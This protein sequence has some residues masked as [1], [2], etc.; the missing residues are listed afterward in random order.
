MRRY[1]LKSTR[2][3]LS[4]LLTGLLACFFGA[5]SFS[6]AASQE[7]ETGPAP[8]FGFTPRPEKSAPNKELRFLRDSTA[9]AAISADELLEDRERKR[10]IGR[11]FADLRFLGKRIQADHIEVQTETRDAVA[12]GNIIFQTD[13][14]RIVGSRIE[15]NLD[16]EK[17]VIYD[18]RGY[19]GATYYITGTVIRRISVDR[20]EIIDGTFTTCEGDNPDWVFRS[21]KATF[22][23]EGYAHLQTPLI[24]LR[25]V[26]AAALPYA[27]FPIKSKRATGF[28]IPTYGFGGRN[29]FE[30]TP[31]FFWAIN[32]WSDTTLGVD[33]YEK[34]GSRYL[35]ELRYILSKDTAGKFNAS[36][37]K[38]ELEKTTLW[39]I[40]GSHSSLLPGNWGFSGVVDFASR[41]NEDRSLE[42]NLVDRVRQDTDTR[43]GF[44]H[45]LGA[46]PG[47]LRVAM[48]RREGLRENDGDL[49][50][51]F[52]EIT[53]DINKAQIGTSE[54]RY[55]I[56]S[57]AVSFYR[58]QNK[59]TTVLQRFDAAPSLS[60]PVQTVPWLGVTANFGL[61]Y[62]Y[63]T[64]QKRTPDVAG[65]PGRDDQKQSPLSREIWFSSFG[66][67][68]PRFSRVY[69]GEFGPFRD[70]KH[71]VSLQTTYSYAPAM[72]SRDRKLII[73]IDSVDRFSDRNTVSYG[74][75]NR[76]L[77]KLKTGDGFETRQ[78]FTASLTQSA[79]IAEARRE[80]NLSG[81]PRRPF[82]DVVLNIQS[83]PI[84][85][86][87]FTH[88]AIYDVYEHEIDEQTT[89]LFLEGG[90][91]WYLGLDR[92]WR[93]R[94]SRGLDPQTGRSDLNFS[95]GYALSRQWFLEY[96]TRINNVSNITL[97]Q[98]IILRYAG[99]CWGFNL[100]FTDTQD[101]S[102]VFFTFTMQG[103][104][105]GE[106]AP[107]FKRRQSVSQEGRFI[108]AGALTPYKFSEPS[109]SQ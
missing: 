30:F 48:R 89:G 16:S 72:D 40:K 99:C 107:T 26:P 97:Q 21:Q 47:S 59:K 69:P 63:W 24:A 44:T 94:R 98:S 13:N 86:I 77:T 50:Q 28:L 88:E 64:D 102:E 79:D 2:F 52:P 100:S 85:L 70:F 73:P 56:E 96:L 43:L 82:G 17:L 54:F 8:S 12:T 91:N 46:L 101:I 55:D 53:W 41:K 58:V 71:I 49:F 68:G 95:A 61:R 22:Q 20:Y 3:Y 42:D 37:F 1:P 51:K 34:R 74:I 78:L 14:D 25:G 10:V 11:G 38:D 36:F 45:D 76:V 105:E 33:Y 9:A 65:I 108:G 83:R 87:R 18:A 35:G 32:K 106:K 90:R 62:T 19:I 92:T 104:L 81:N 6:P 67:A 80:Q 57:S 15:F 23:I 7:Q 29:G 31:R 109:T 27:I 75:I 66:I 4:P 39:D 60:L 93:R 5:A 103:L 84:S